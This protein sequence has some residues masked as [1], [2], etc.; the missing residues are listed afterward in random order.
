MQRE[1][2]LSELEQGIINGNKEVSVGAATNALSTGLDALDAINNGL[3][4]GMTIVGDRYAIHEIYLPQV[5]M[6]ADAMYGA[7][8]ILI[9]A[10][11][12]EASAARKGVVIGV[13]EGDVHDIGKNIVK[14]ML[15][16]G[17][18]DVN[19]LGR[20]VPIESFVDTAEG[21][22]A[23]IVAMSTLMTP[24]MDGMK[25]VIDGLIESGYRSKVKTII[26]G[27][28][29]SPEFAEDIGA[30]MHAISAQEA[31][32]KLKEAVN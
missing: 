25:Q 24:T 9:P 27:A 12:V 16:A 1:E 32:T 7:L 26:G 13:I 10:I 4:K 28:P 3:I 14:A 8:D 23:K 15:T 19:D 21:H 22:N 17:G 31:V 11:P 6:S 29:T 30:D 20:D 5:L 2:I 18:Y